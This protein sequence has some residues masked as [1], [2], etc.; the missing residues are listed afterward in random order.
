MGLYIKKVTV[1]PNTPMNNPFTET[2]ELEGNIL[3][4]IQYLFP[5]G[6]CQKVGVRILYGEYQISPANEGQWI[7]GHGEVVRDVLKLPLP[8]KKTV[9]RI[10]AYNLS[11]HFEHTVTLRFLVV[12]EK[13]YSPLN[14]LV[15]LLKKL[16]GVRK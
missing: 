1:S 7:D 12:D 15:S 6:L 5:T 9:L 13:Q 4:E 8:E 3:E 2:I 14:D 10:Q 11:E 16:L